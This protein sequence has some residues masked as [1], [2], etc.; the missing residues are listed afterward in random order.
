MD[1]RTHT[2]THARRL[3]YTVRQTTVYFIFIFSV[4]G[5][6]KRKLSHQWL[7]ENHWLR[8]SPSL[9]ALYCVYCCLFG[10]RDSREKTFIH[11]VRDWKNLSALIKRHTAKGG[12]HD[13]CVDAGESYLL[14][15]E[16][17]KP[18]I[19]SSVSSQHEQDVARNRH[20]LRKIIEVIILCGRQNIPIRGH[21]EE[22]SNF[23]AILQSFAKDDPLLSQHLAIHDK[24]ATYTSPD[25]QNEIIKLCGDHVRDTIVQ[26]CNN[27]PCFAVI[28]DE[29][30]DVSTREQVSLCIRFLD[31]KDGILY[32]REEFIGFIHTVSLKSEALAQ[33]ILNA[34]QDNG[35]DITK[36]RAQCYDGAANMA[37]KRSGVQARIRQ[38]VPLAYYV[39]CKAH[40]LNLALVHS[41]KEACVRTM[42]STVQDIA[43]AFEY[44]S[45][46]LE[47]FSDELQS[48][49]NTKDQME[50]RTKL[51]TLC[52]TR[53][54][55]RADALYTFKTAFPVIVH[56]LE[57]LQ[58][59]GDDKAGQFLAAI[60]RFDFIIT[61]VVSEHVLSGTVALTKFLQKPECDLLEAVKEAKVVIQRLRDERNDP[62]VWD[63]LYTRAIDIAATFNIQPD[64]PRRI[65]RQQHRANYAVQNPK[66]YWRV[67]VFYVFVDHL[68]QEIDTR[69]LQNE[70]RYN[71]EYL[72]PVKT[73]FLTPDMALRIY[74]TYKE[75]LSSD[76]DSFKDEIS[77]WTV[78]WRDS[79]AKPS[80]LLDTINH[81]SCNLYPCIYKIFSILLA[82]PASSATAE[83][84]FSAM[85]RIKNFLRA[86]MADERLS[87]L[88]MMHVHREIPIDT[89]V[90]INTFATQKDR[91]LDFI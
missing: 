16:Q 53:W 84:S 47:A 65:G 71:A 12:Q 30:T 61:L 44:S 7:R 73:R 27:S 36:I 82:M 70:E 91:V 83:R 60:L 68:T 6:Q 15:Q 41:S 28:A 51:R 75:D 55:S 25:I 24:K 74:N 54:S 21:T 72:L 62:L 39:H 18:S 3:T 59:D 63:E 45:K 23:M 38:I 4:F 19:R 87:G 26:S 10:N 29:A 11:P 86:T 33:V 88:A 13:G 1:I 89:D 77:R 49:D 42:M 43:F 31:S 37:G 50:N 67:A 85:R 90:I 78:K 35:L 79:D 69:L 66:D 14:I 34:L 56:A 2:C 58:D 48:D 80:K 5:G 32:V 9:D 40:C 64:V 8:Y 20:S 52:E 46:R 57:A 81:T 76:V 17:K 22:K